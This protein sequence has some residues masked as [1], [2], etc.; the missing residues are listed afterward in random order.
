[1]EII[2]MNKTGAKPL[3]LDPDDKQQEH[4]EYIDLTDQDSLTR[5]YKSK[6]KKKKKKASGAKAQQQQQHHDHPKGQKK[7]HRSQSNKKPNSGN[8]QTQ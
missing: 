5:F 3:S 6:K 4:K 1:M 2:D 8:T 7:K